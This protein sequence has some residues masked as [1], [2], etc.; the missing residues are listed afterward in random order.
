VSL[1]EEYAEAPWIEMK[2]DDSDDNGFN[3]LFDDPDPYDTFVH[4]FTPA[5]GSGAEDPPSEGAGA[6]GGGGGDS[7]KP[8]TITLRGHRADIGQTLNSTGLTLW[9][10]AP[11]L[12]QFMVDNADAYIRGKHVLE[13]GGG[14]GLC[15]ILAGMLDAKSVYI[16][17]GDSESLAG[18]RV[19]VESNAVGSAVRCR[20]L[21]WGMQLPEF[22]RHVS[23]D[24]RT[25]GRF[26][27]LIGSDIIY[28]ESILDPL[29]LTVDLLLTE[30]STGTFI[31]AYARRNVKI[32][33][34]FSTA[35]KFN[36]EWTLPDGEEGCFVFRRKQM[37]DVDTH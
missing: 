32:D 14:L 13:L 21:R 23:P 19:N 27:V 10:A 4:T 6:G 20:Q 5:M 34:V 25:D 35:E 30:D 31:L 15:G 22:A 9:R 11:I 8:M 29:F 16:T 28:V 2:S 33:L 17:D 36:F 12:C 7:G 1:M 37:K 24:V 18:M 26:D 3:G